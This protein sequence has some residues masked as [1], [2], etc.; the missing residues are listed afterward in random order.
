MKQIKFFAMALAAF[1]MFSCSKED[2]VE[3]SGNNAPS[4]KAAITVKFANA[5]DA[6]SRA[7]GVPATTADAKIVDYSI[8][9]FRGDGIL[10]SKLYGSGKNITTESKIKVT[11]TTAAKKI[12]VVANAG[13]LTPTIGNEAALLAKLVKLVN[14]DVNVA[15]QVT[16]KVYMSGNTDFAFAQGSNTAQVPV[17]LTFVGARLSVKVVTSAKTQGVSGTNFTI[18]KAFVLN[19]GGV[20]KLFGTSLIPTAAELSTNPYFTMGE[21]P[22]GK[23]PAWTNMPAAGKYTVSSSM[24]TPFATEAAVTAGAHFYVFEQDAKAHGVIPTTLVVEAKWI[25]GGNKIVYFPVKFNTSD[26][27][28]VI[29]RGKSY[30]VKVTLNGNFLDPGNGGNGGGGTEDPGED[31]IASDVEVAITPA[32][33]TAVPLEKTFE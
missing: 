22:A 2:N 15:S 21:N 24:S 1:M 6:N 5:T 28:T 17:N 23:S 20:S 7:T 18:T 26:M 19:A 16:G 9:L 4:E 33:W 25:S 11:G 27:K 14:T 30:E 13:D 29:V 8:F 10:D 31:L 3:T 12:Y 32:T